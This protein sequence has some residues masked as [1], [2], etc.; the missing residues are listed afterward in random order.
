MQTE[1]FNTEVE[2]DE[3][4]TNYGVEVFSIKTIEGVNLDDNN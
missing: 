2:A 1:I 3:F 4:A